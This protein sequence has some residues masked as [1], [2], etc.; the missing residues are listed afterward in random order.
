MFVSL[1]GA[2]S[3]YSPTYG[4]GVAAEHIIKGFEKNGIDYRISDPEAKVEIYW[5]HPPYEFTRARNYK[6]GFTAWEST[7]FKKDWEILM[8]EADEIWTPSTWLSDHFG[9]VLDKPTFT[10]PHGVDTDWKPFR[11][12]KPEYPFPF[13]FLHI[14]EPQFRKN[15]QLVVE[16]FAELFGNNDNFQLVMKTAGINTTR[17]YSEPSH[18]ILGNPDAIYRNI[19]FIDTILDKQQLVELHNK[20]HCMI[21]PTAGEGFGFHPLEALASGLPTITTVGWCD[22]KD[23]VS[24]PIETPL[25]P[26]KWEYLHPGD[27]FNP[28]KE[29]IKKAMLEMVENYEK[30]CA[31]AFKNSFLVHK[32]WNWD[33]QNAKA[34]EKIKDIL[35]SSFIKDSMV[36]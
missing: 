27:M 12:Y 4:Y 21:Y 2:F 9:K 29:Q 10:Y 20:S 24:V 34:A 18:S 36:N 13:R 25:T 23:F 30:Y 17:I 31:E 3:N 35:F 8:Q 6:I 28:T 32:E 15:G 5:G 7:G 16:A 1:S 22:Y 33:R 26:S 19:V 14:G 11:R